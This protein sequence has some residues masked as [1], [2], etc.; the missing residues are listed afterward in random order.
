MKLLKFGLFVILL[1]ISLSCATSVTGNLDSARFS[2]DKCSTTNTDACLTA[3]DKADAV[4]A[5]DPGNFEAALLKSSALATAGRVDLLSIMSDMMQTEDES[6]IDQDTQKFRFIRS[7]LSDDTNITYL[8]EAVLALSNIVDGG[9]AP[10]D[11]T[12]DGYR[13]FYFQIGFLQALE[14]FVRP[15]SLAQP[16]ADAIVDLNAIELITDDDSDIIMADMLAADNNLVE[17]GISNSDVTGWELVS[18]TRRNYC[19]IKN[20]NAANDAF[21]AGELRALMRCQLNPSDTIAALDDVNGD[22]PGTDITGCSD[23]DYDQCAGTD[24]TP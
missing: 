10:E 6:G 24:T 20:V 16:A 8:R 18:M 5:S 23:F 19:A 2:L 4:L 14:A 12:V 21:T 11:N 15:T 9:Y 7:V 13:D 17:G 22:F 3:S 1:A